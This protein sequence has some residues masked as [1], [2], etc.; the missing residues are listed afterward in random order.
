VFGSHFQ[1]PELG[2]IGANG[3]ANAHSFQV[4]TAWFEQL[5]LEGHRYEIVNKFQGALFTASQVK[6][7]I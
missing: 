1:L 4:P 7:K 3:L 5:E 6:P 2:P